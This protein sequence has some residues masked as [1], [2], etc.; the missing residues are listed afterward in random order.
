MTKEERKFIKKFGEGK[1]CEFRRC[2]KLV[3]QEKLKICEV[4]RITGLSQRQ[5]RYWRSKILINL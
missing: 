5:V 2:L 3:I 1:L 4:E